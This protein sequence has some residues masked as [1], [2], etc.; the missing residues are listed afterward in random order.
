MTKAPKFFW[1][2]PKNRKS[3]ARHLPC[4]GLSVDE[5]FHCRV[6]QTVVLGSRVRLG[7]SKIAVT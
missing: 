2:G 1:G 6:G 3:Q 7:G 4:L 5:A